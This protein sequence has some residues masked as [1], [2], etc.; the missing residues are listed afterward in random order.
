MKAVN[1]D[2]GNFCSMFNATPELGFTGQWRMVINVIGDAEADARARIVSLI[3]DGAPVE[4]REVKYSC[5]Q[6]N[7]IK[8]GPLLKALGPDVSETVNQWG[9]DVVADALFVVTRGPQPDLKAELEQ[10]F[11]DKIVVTEGSPETPAPI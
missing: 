1:K 10:K 4:W 7:R 2:D 11:G 8:K 6:L 3:P 9:V 5:A